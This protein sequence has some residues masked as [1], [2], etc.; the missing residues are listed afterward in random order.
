MH[1]C[2]S[3]EHTMCKHASQRAHGCQV[4]W[5]WQSSFQGSRAPAG[6]QQVVREKFFR[7]VRDEM[8]YELK[9]GDSQV[10]L[11][12]DG[13]IRIELPVV[14]SNMRVRLCLL[15][16]HLFKRTFNVVRTCFSQE[17]LWLTSLSAM[18][19]KL[20]ILARH[21]K[22]I[23]EAPGNTLVAGCFCTPVFR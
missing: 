5:V 21:M 13:S 1:I 15:A 12:R 8:P 4:I 22:C 17:C 9:F 14:V 3:N 16:L 19:L 11:L 20:D 10:D 6:L 18:Q 23:G 2:V 7:R